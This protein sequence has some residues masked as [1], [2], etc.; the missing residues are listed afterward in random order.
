M[1]YHKPYLCT[2]SDGQRFFVH[3]QSRAR[4]SRK[5]IIVGHGRGVSLNPFLQDRE[6]CIADRLD[7]IFTRVTA[8]FDID[9]QL[10]ESVSKWS[11]EYIGRV[12]NLTLHLWLGT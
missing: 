6:E 4:G 7:G 11:L 2:I 12:E 8:A 5:L 3:R 10:L 9:W 1:P